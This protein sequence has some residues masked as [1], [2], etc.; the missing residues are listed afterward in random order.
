MDIK[1]PSI[2]EDFPQGDQVVH[3]KCTVRT[4][5]LTG[6]GEMFPKLFCLDQSAADGIMAD[7]GANL[8][9]ADSEMHLVNC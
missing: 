6:D 7:T 5:G 3:L 4:I 8:C 9:M 2:E 1:P